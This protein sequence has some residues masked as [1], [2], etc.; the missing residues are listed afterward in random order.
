[1]KYSEIEANYSALK[2]LEDGKFPRKIQVAMA[3]NMLLL[4]PI[5]EFI[6]TQRTNSLK[7]H[8]KIKE[9]GS[10]DITMKEDG[11]ASV[12]F[13]TPEDLSSFMEE[14]K[15][16]LSTEEDISIVKIDASDLGV[17]EIDPRFD[18]LSVKQELSLSFMIVYSEV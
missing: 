12:N 15:A 14:E 6:K 8:A 1:M 18:A 16:L 13:K 11:S 9:D 2:S 5:V 3:R 10:F 4:E 17:Y 7:E